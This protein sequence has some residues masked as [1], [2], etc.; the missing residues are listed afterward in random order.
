MIILI[1]I[2]VEAIACVIK[3]LIEDSEDII[4]LLLI[5]GIIESKFISNPIHILN[6]VYAEIEIKVLM[7]KFNP[8][9]TSGNQKW[10]GA[11]PIFKKSPEFIIIR[12]FELSIVE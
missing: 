9:R 1:R 10:S 4:F 6:H 7:I 2:T 11:I 3:Y 5:M 12:R 8:S